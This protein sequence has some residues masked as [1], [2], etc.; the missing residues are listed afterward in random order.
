MFRLTPSCYKYAPAGTVL[1]QVCPGCR[2]P[3][4]R[5]PRLALSY[6]SYVLA[7]AVLLQ[8]CLGWRCPVTAMSWL[9][10]SCY[11]YVLAGAVL[12]QLCL[13]WRCP[14][15]AMSWHG[16][17]LVPKLKVETQNVGCHLCMFV[18]LLL[19]WTISLVIS[20]INNAN[21]PS[22]KASFGS[23]LK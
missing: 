10:L 17:K 19:L 15:T 16:R 7:G 18:Y 1:I 11:S 2:C 4:T 21:T 5:M 14:V 20:D 9:V 23:Q 6:Y 3:V 13:G 12:F 22:E 8:L